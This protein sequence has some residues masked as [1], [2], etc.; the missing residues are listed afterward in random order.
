MESVAILNEKKARIII[1]TII[2]KLNHKN[3]KLTKNTK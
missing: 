1:K 3:S 2:E